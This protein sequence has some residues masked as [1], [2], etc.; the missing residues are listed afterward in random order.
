MK[1]ETFI[2]I[3]DADFY[4][5]VPDSQLKELC[6]FLLERYGVKSN[7]HIIAA[8]EGNCVALAAGH[9]LATGHPAVV[10]MQNSGEGN[11][12]NPIVSLLKIYGIPVIFVIGWRGEPGIHDEPQHVYQGEMTISL[13]ELLG[14]DSF[15]LAEKTTEEEA[16]Q[17]MEQFR[18]KLRSGESVA[19]VV[20]KNALQYQGKPEVKNVGLMRREDILR[21]ILCAAKGDVVL[22][23][24]GKTSREIFE[25]RKM[26]GGDHSHDFL[27]VGS[28]GHSS[29][30]AL[31]V[32]LARPERKVW[33]IDGD[34]AVLMHMGALAVI[35]ALKPKNFIHVVINNGAHESVGGMPTVMRNID[36]TLV[37]KGC[38]YEEVVRVENPV[39]LKD[40]LKSVKKREQLVMLEVMSAVG[41][42]ADLGR[43]TIAPKENVTAFMKQMAGPAIAIK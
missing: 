40:V 15:V 18:A 32:A 37:A 8:N 36:L 6:N 30:I 14:I 23:T 26:N 42:R 34:G 16:S 27:T 22:S 25:L 35:G 4:V 9:Y 28:M 7:A 20:R 12:V 21:Q 11:A 29:S 39:E 13:L 5:G 2:Q 38:G 33:C 3:L 41:A 31:G 1:A 10:Y 17:K 43:P 19:F 24:T